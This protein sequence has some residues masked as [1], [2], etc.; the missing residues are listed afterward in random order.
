MA[1]QSQMLEKAKKQR[2]YRALGLV[3][4]GLDF[5]FPKNSENSN[6]SGPTNI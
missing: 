4:K 6:N 3:Q 5:A 1:I 2:R